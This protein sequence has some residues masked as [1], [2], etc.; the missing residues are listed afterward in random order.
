MKVHKL[1]GIDIGSNS[2]RLLVSNVITDRKNTLFK[3]S[4]LTRLPI[5][6]GSDSF[7]KGKIAK[8]NINRLVTG[9]RAYSNIMDVHGV[10]QYRACA[11]SALREASNGEEVCRM[12]LEETGINIELIDGKEEAKMI[13]NSDMID[14]IRDQEDSFLYMDVGGGS[15][16]FTLF[17]GNQIKA[18]RSFKIGTIRLL[19]GMVHKDDWDVMRDWIRAETKGMGEVLMVGSG[20]NINRTFKMSDRKAGQPLSLD[21]IENTYNMLLKFT[22]EERM[23]K[24]DL[25]P[26]RADVITHALKIYKSAMTWAGSERMLVPKKGLADGIVRYLFREHV[27]S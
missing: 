26:D 12:V 11:T 15:T 1:A 18:S 21:Y 4:S 2:V 24:F 10:E 16:E 7:G 19:N 14:S 27:L 20:G 3:K 9:M 23:I 25:N 5:R 13:F 6:L 8:K 17:Y 22:P